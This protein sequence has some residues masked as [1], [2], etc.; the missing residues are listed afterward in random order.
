MTT[1]TIME[2]THQALDVV[3]NSGIHDVEWPYN[4]GHQTLKPVDRRTMQSLMGAIRAW[5]VN[6][7]RKYPEGPPD[8]HLGE[9]RRFQ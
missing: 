3:L 1:V 5:Y 9:F 6:Y 8:V 2:K 4:A 7:K